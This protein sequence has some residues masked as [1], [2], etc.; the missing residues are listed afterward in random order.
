[1]STNRARSRRTDEEDVRP[2]RS[3]DTP[4]S[5]LPPP[6]VLPARHPYNIVKRMTY[7][8]LSLY[9]LHVMEVWHQIFHSPRVDHQWFKIGL[10]VSVGKSGVEDGIHY[11]LEVLEGSLNYFMTN[12]NKRNTALTFRLCNFVFINCESVASRFC[13]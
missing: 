7:I 10:A 2:L 6:N 11:F 9:G 13:F 3:G 8:S 1:M 4:F 5:A 12:F